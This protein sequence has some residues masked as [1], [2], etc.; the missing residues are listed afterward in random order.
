MA[1]YSTGTI[2]VTNGSGAVTG[3]STNFT[4]NAAVGEGLVGP[5]GRLYEITAISSATAMTISPVYAGSTA[6]GQAYKIAPTQSYIR[7]LAAQAAQLLNDF[8]D[9]R[10]Q[11]GAGMFGDGTVSAP[12]MRFLSDQDTG[13]RRTGT[14]SLALVAGGADI[15]TADSVGVTL[16]GLLRAGVSSGS[17]HTL[18]RA[19]AGGGGIVALVYGANDGT[20]LCDGDV[21]TYNG[22]NTCQFVASV[23]STG[24]SLSAA[25]TVGAGGADPAEYQYKA[26]DCGVVRKGQVVGIDAEDRIT[27]RWADA[28]DFAIKSADPST[29][30]GDRWGSAANIL[31]VHGVAHPGAA[32]GLPEGTTPEE[33]EAHAA[34]LAAWTAAKAAFDAAHE[35]E[36]AKV[37]RISHGGGRL[38]C[39]VAGTVTAGQYVIAQ[40]DG[41][42]GIEAVCA[43]TV[44]DADRWRIVGRVRIANP[45]EAQV[46]NLVKEDVPYDPDW[47]AIV[48]QM[49]G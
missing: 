32:P 43:A 4:A 18:R 22:A 46:R 7:D 37:D 23:S 20:T 38:P 28:I 12:G 39:I 2:S 24:R 26:G 25:G 35:L 3:S 45:T 41:D 13:V 31:A 9:V 47:S 33:I 40:D 11:A 34:A 42:G 1:W 6:S 8:G 10:D 49:K 30:G 17:Y 15:A 29:V 21:S 27:D 19:A 16:P 44:T 5:D 14:N 36:R 48:V